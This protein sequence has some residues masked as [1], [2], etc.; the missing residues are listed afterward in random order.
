MQEELFRQ[1]LGL[2]QPWDVERVA[3]DVARSRIDLYVVWRA[4]SAP[5][6]ACGA[7]EQ[8][9]HD[10]RGRSWRHLDFF[11]FEA[12][13]HCELPR[14]AC[15]ACQGTTQLGVPWAREGS[16]FTLMFEAL[17]LTLARE[18]PVSACARILRCSDNALW[19]QIDAHVDLARAKESYAD[20]HVIGIDETSYAK[21][22]SYITLVHDLSK[23]QLIYATPGKDASTVQRFT[24]DFKTHQGKLEAIKVVCMDMSK[25][26]IAGA[27]KYL[28]AAAVAFDGF[29]VVQLANKAVDAVRREEARD[30]GW[31][32]KTRWCWLKDQAQWTAKERDKMDW[33]PHSRLK[34]ARAWRIKEALRDIYA[35]SRSDAAQSA[36]SLKKWL[37]LAQRSQLHPIKELA[38]TIKQHWAGI[39]TAF[40]AAHLHTGYVEA[41][42]SLL[43]AAKAKARGYG[44]TRHFIAMAF[45]IAGKLSHLPA[46]PLRKARA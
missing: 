6:P 4:S 30:E 34:T 32:K 8:K 24:E 10:H 17:A 15:S 31:L 25:A 26:F 45:L 40:E 36:Q 12:Y 44:S 2:T 11:Q 42:N 38:K 46:N 3:L 16:R 20:T 18:M 21:G 19:R 23:G 41:V 43:Q 5:C 33:M 35:N 22:H 28:P 29:H 14:I 13:V 9:I 7:A 37:H 27:A 1:A 39:L